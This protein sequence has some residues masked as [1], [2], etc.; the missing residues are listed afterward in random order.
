MRFSGRLASQVRRRPEQ[1][2]RSLSV[3][4]RNEPKNCPNYQWRRWLRFTESHFGDGF[5]METLHARAVT[6]I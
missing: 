1:A 2:C 5:R 6:S 3:K 4:T